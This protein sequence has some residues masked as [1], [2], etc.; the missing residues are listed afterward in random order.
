MA[1]YRGYS[2]SNNAYCAYL[3]G[4]KPKSKWTKQ[5]ILDCIEEINANASALAR[6]LTAQE[7]RDYCLR[8]T[9]WHHTSMYYNET[10]FYSINEDFCER[11]NADIVENIIR[12][13]K[14]RIK[15]ET[16]PNL[17]ITAYVKYDQ[18]E[19]TRKHP[20][21]VTYY[22]KVKY[23]SNDKIV[24]CDLHTKRLS[25]LTI[26]KKIEQ[27]TKYADFAKLKIWGKTC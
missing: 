27:K 12:D 22:A 6:R 24:D 18:W 21:K 26:I 20:K 5:D 9:S 23:R 1:G 10:Y 7:L 15:K 17:Y 25:G 8:R 3:D 14:P 13:R 11:L 16:V 4:E 19:G 2:M